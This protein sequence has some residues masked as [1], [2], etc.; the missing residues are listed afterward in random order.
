M[1]DSGHRFTS[2]EDKA[3]II[4]FIKDYL[5]AE[6]NRKHPVREESLEGRCGTKL[7]DVAQQQNANDCGVHLIWNVSLYLQDRERVDYPGTFGNMK[8]F[9]KKIRSIFDE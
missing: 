2:E 8:F 3:S 1:I 5:F 6:W 9:R 7:L 4:K